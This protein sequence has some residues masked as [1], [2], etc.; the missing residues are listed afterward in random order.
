MTGPRDVDAVLRSPADGDLTSDET[1]TFTLPGGSEIHGKIG[2]T[3]LI[4]QG[5]AGDTLKLTLKATDDHHKLE[6]THTDAIDGDDTDFPRLHHLPIPP[7]KS[8]GWSL[9]FDETGGANFGEVEAWVEL[10]EHAVV[11]VTP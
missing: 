6:L 11:P 9:T 2:V 1:D 4:P 7:S 10:V 3:V 8:E 5:S